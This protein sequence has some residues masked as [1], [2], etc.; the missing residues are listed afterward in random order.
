M[1]LSSVTRVTRLTVGRV[2]GVQ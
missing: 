1:S 2:S